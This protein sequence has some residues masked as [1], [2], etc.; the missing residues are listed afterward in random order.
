[1]WTI[2][3]PST[4]AINKTDIGHSPTERQLVYACN[5]RITVW[6]SYIF[7]IHMQPSALF[8][9]L[10]VKLWMWGMLQI[11]IRPITP[12]DLHYVNDKLQRERI[13]LSVGLVF[14][15]ISGSWKCSTLDPFNKLFKDNEKNHFIFKVTSSGINIWASHRIRLIEI[16]PEQI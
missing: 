10:Y 1:M 13:W 14:C 7:W 4:Y 2:C 9:P 16:N 12:I 3:M 15:N 11:W 5:D 6:M 8:F